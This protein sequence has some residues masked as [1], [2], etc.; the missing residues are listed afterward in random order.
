[1]VENSFVQ[2]HIV[3]DLSS[4]MGCKLVDQWGEC[5]H[6]T[7]VSP[8]W[9]KLWCINVVGTKSCCVIVGAGSFF[10]E[11]EA[12]WLRSFCVMQICDAI[13]NKDWEGFRYMCVWI[14]LTWLWA[15]RF[16]TFHGMIFFVSGDQF[17]RILRSTKILWCLC[18]S[19]VGR[20]SSVQ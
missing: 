5:R 3:V 2:E 16:I 4:D 6:A 19:C 15:Q 9:D 8:K 10:C 14:K 11:S 17:L 12:V 1:M 18:A 7:W 20:V 13:Y